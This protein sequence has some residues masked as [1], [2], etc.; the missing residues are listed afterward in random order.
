[1]KTVHLVYIT[2]TDG[3]QIVVGVCHTLDAAKRMERRWESENGVTKTAIR[4][5]PIHETM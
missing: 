3:S 5:M 2:M 4:A 1:M